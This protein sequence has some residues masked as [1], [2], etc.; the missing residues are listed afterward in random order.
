VLIDL[1]I[2]NDIIFPAAGYMAMAIEAVTQV[3]KDCNASFEGYTFQ[4]LRIA[5]PLILPEEGDIEILFN[6]RVLHQSTSVETSK[7]F[8]F[9]VSSVTTK[10]K[11]TEHVEGLIAAEEIYIGI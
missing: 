7:W 5:S 2:G 1:K 3:Y 11:W 6:L 4:N 10:G 8:D 9:R